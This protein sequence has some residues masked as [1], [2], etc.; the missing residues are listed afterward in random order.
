MIEY[1][2]QQMS[3]CIDEHIHNQMHRLVLKLRFIDGLTYEKI[4]EHPDVDRTPRQVS[5]IINK[6]SV[7]LSKYLK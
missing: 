3:E 1:T 5:N 4:S 7:Q 6:Y 2:N